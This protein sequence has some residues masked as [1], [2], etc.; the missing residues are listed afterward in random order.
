MMRVLEDQRAAYQSRARG[1]K[2]RIYSLYGWGGI[3]RV[4]KELG[5]APNIYLVNI[6]REIHGSSRT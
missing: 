1:L 3:S 4:A 2:A 5:I 6:G